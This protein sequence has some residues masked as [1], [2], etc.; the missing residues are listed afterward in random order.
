MA[1]ETAYVNAGQVYKEQTYFSG[2]Y[3][4]EGKFNYV[5]T[6]TGT[7]TVDPIAPFEKHQDG[8]IKNY[9]STKEA[10][11]WYSGENSGESLSGY[12][13]C[14]SV[15]LWWGKGVLDSENYDL[16]FRVDSAE[17][18]QIISSYYSLPY[19]INSSIENQMS[20]PQNKFVY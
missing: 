6:R 7:N 13:L 18:L 3:D 8:E 9:T 1:G 17:Q 16:Y 20:V 14:P 12:D 19:P 15:T 5:T 10:R 11:A 2:N 4:P